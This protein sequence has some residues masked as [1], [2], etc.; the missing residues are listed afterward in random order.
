MLAAGS[1]TSWA[2]GQELHVFHYGL[3]SKS[4][5]WGY[6]WVTWNST[7]LLAAFSRECRPMWC[8]LQHCRL[9]AVSYR[10]VLLPSLAETMD[11]GTVLLGTAARVDGIPRWCAVNAMTIGINASIELMETLQSTVLVM[12]L[13]STVTVMHHHQLCL[14]GLREHCSS[15]WLPTVRRRIQN[16]Y[17]STAIVDLAQ[18]KRVGLSEAV[19]QWIMPVDKIDSIN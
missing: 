19:K 2:W 6:W 9:L 11:R 12:T 18:R 4:S 17:R 8:H 10:P 15:C 3:K 13:Q 7:V 16:A 14:A 5:M 1:L